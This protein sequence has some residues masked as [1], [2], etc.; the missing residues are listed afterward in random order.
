MTRKA[1]SGRSSAADWPGASTVREADQ[2][3]RTTRLHLDPTDAAFLIRRLGE[4]ALARDM[5]PRKRSSVADKRTV[6]LKGRELVAQVEV[7]LDRFASVQSALPSRTGAQSRDRGAALRGDLPGLHRQ[8]ERLLA[9]LEKLHPETVRFL[10]RDE[11]GYVDEVRAC[12]STF[13]V[14]TRIGLPGKRRRGNPRGFKGASAPM[15]MAARRFLAEIVGK[16]FERAKLAISTSEDS[17][18]MDTLASCL[19][20]VG[21]AETDLRRLTQAAKSRGREPLA[22]RDPRKKL[23]E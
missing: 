17:V 10:E 5:G 19:R 16:I 18:Y 2:S 3:G 11:D 7:A 20:A 23:A 6:Q 14:F 13:E 4:A 12:L 1:E 15:E 22:I 8:V 9:T 21:L